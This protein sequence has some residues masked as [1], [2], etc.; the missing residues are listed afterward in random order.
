MAV[1]EIFS[2]GCATC[3]S[4][5]RMVRDIA[6]PECTVEVVPVTT[7]DGQRRAASYGARRVPA[8]AVNGVLAACC[9]GEMPSRWALE[10]AI[11][12]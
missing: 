11:G 1:I 3:D 9:R 4:A 6:C 2:A 8:V 10:A 12:A 7:P 5:E